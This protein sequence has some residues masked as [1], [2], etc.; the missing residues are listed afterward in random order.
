MSPKGL[1]EYFGYYSRIVRLMVSNYDFEDVDDFIEKIEA[2]FDTILKTT[3]VEKGRKARVKACKKYFCTVLVQSAIQAS[4]A[5]EFSEWEKLRKLNIKI[6]EIFDELIQ[7]KSKP[8]LE[9]LSFKVLMADLGART[10]KD[11]WYYSQMEDIS[12]VPVPKSIDIRRVL[13]LASIRSFRKAAELKVAHWPALVF[14]TRPLS[15]QEIV[16]ICPAVLSEEKLFARAIFGLR[17]ARTMSSSFVSKRLSIEDGSVVE[18]YWR[19]DK[20]EKVTIGLTNYETTDAQFESA[21][22][23]TPDRSL[24]RFEKINK[25]TN[26]ILRSQS[27]LDYVV[28][29]ECAIP[30]R[31]A[32]GVAQKL[33]TQS[34]SLLAGIEYIEF[35]KKKKTLRNTCLI[36]LVSYWPGYPSSIVVLQDK[37]MPSHGEAVKLKAVKKKQFQSTSPLEESLPLYRHGDFQFGVLLCSDLT[38]PECRVRYQGKIDCLFVLEWN[39]DVKTFSFLIEGAAHDIHTFVVQAN[40]RKY[41]DSR[42]R[43]P[44]RVDFKRDSVRVKGGLDDF[45]AIGEVD[46]RSLRKFQNKGN[47]AD[48]ESEFKPVPIG[49]KVSSSRR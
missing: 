44:Y 14:S 8:E 7:K 35:R 15:I 27:R 25:L 39:P 2:C 40:N 30:H 9:S 13:R 16:L 38:N 5:R 45:Y 41:G 49:F 3:L 43:A 17:G 19:K 22:L 31:W 12:S 37:L 23:G 33:A 28:F 10:Y 20:R 24:E 46:Y 18:S 47:M 34:V 29:P 11:Y 32:I 42:I 21:L 48:K 36:S 6:Q 26:D 4:T 1:F